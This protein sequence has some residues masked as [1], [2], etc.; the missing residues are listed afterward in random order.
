MWY[1]YSY[2]RMYFKLVSYIS[3]NIMKF[4]LTDINK[5][6]TVIHTNMHY[7]VTH[8][9]DLNYVTIYSLIMLTGNTE[10]AF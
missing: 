7:E 6:V 4:F 2:Q 5:Q 8:T 10:Q 1:K 3:L 9:Q